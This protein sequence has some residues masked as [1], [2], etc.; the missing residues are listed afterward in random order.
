MLRLSDA[1]PLSEIVRLLAGRQARG[2]ANLRIDRLASLESADATS[3]AFLSS[4]AYR[5]QARA[6]QAGVVVTSVE[7]ADAV[8]ANVALIEVPD[9][10]RA[11]GLIARQFDAWINPE[12]HHRFIPRP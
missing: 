1:V 7:M 6:T 2:A 10:Y 5:D 3:I 4:R 12:A 9:P 8:P 11:Y